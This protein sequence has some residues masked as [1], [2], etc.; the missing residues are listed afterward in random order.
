[1]PIHSTFVEEPD[2]EGGGLIE[3]PAAP[4]IRGFSVLGILTYASTILLVLGGAGFY[5]F[6]LQ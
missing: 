4:V 1:M 6:W 3:R 2:T 5:V